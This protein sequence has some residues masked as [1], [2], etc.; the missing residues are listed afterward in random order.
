MKADYRD[1]ALFAEASALYTCLRKS[2]SGHLN[3][4]AE[5]NA[6][7]SGRSAVFKGSVADELTATSRTQICE[8]DLHSG[9]MRMLAPGPHNDRLPKYRPD[10][11]EIAFLSDRQSSGNFQ[12]YFLDVATGAVTGTPNVDGWVEY[13]HWSPDGERILLGVAG[14]GADVGGV[15]GAVPSRQAAEE[16]PSWMPLVETGEEAYRWRRLWLYWSHPS[17]VASLATEPRCMLQS[18]Q[19]GRTPRPKV[20]SPNSSS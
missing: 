1:E 18:T 5:V 20:R 14:H 16:K 7:E 10:E 19:L 9:A 6:S 15:P 3:D 11:S 12:L 4:A 2:A 8:I 13:F 17:P